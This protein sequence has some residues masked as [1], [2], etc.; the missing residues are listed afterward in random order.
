MMMRVS[1]RLVERSFFNE[2]RTLFRTWFDEDRAPKAIIGIRY[3]NNFLLSPGDKRILGLEREDLV[4]VADYD[5]VRNSLLYLGKQ[6]PGRFS[7]LLW[8]VFR[9][10]PEVNSVV[11]VQ[12]EG[13]VFKDVK[14]LDM[15]MTYI[16]S[17]SSLQ[18]MPFFKKNKA[19]RLSSGETVFLL[20]DLSSAESILKGLNP[21]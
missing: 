20:D 8:F 9:T 3:G 16:N 18:A 17:Q 1:Q 5:P 12:D 4:E 19:G 10:F 14:A 2:L 15:D 6:A 7:P 11:I 21:A 13:E